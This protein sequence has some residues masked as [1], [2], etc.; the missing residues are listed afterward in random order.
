MIDGRNTT[1]QM[2]DAVGLVT[3]LAMTLLALIVVAVLFLA[4]EVLIPVALAVLLSFVLAPAVRRLEEWRL[5][6]AGA[7][8]IVLLA[9]VG[10]VFGLGSVVGREA[11]KLGV[12]RQSV[13]KVWLAERLG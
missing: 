9:A 11:S 7:I 5:P 12:T 1:K 4:R 10:I 13:I 2:R 8:V 3:A 6:R